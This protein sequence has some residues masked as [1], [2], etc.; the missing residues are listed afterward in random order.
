MP[1]DDKSQRETPE[2]SDPEAGADAARTAPDA[3]RAA[4]EAPKTD[5]I[6]RVWPLS[7][8]D[9]SGLG[10]KGWAEVKDDRIGGHPELETT[11][12]SGPGGING[13]QPDTDPKTG[14]LR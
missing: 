2:A 3:K 13:P 10:D 5:D 12:K 11:T 7:G 6:H 9:R 14:A 8:G 4:H 1:N